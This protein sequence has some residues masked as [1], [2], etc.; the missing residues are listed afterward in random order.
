MVAVKMTEPSTF[1]YCC[2]LMVIKNGKALLDRSLQG[3]RMPETGICLCRF[4][5]G[6]LRHYAVGECYGM[7]KEFKGLVRAPGPP[8]WLDLFVA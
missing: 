4:Q 6:Y 7:S 3:A 1:S 8:G 2:L 5:I